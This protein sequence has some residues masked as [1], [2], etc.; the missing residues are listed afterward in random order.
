MDAKD[1]DKARLLTQSMEDP[2]P[3]RLVVKRQAEH[4]FE[5]KNYIEAAKNYFESEESFD[6]VVLKFMTDENAEMKRGL[7]KY[8]LLRLETDRDVVKI[9]LLVW[10]I[11]E[12][13]LSELSEVRRKEGGG[14]NGGALK[15]QLELFLQKPIVLNCLKENTKAA[16]K[17]IISHLDF[18]THIILSKLL[19]G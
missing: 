18:D 3:F 19:K 6:A 10:W 5:E 4:Y 16:Y 7:K 11:L 14:N 17:L 12:I 8:L 13:F 1:F 9:T 2:H 15:K